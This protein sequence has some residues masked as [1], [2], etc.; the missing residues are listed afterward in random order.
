VD[1][2]EPI[3]QLS[4]QAT[5]F[6]MALTMSPP[7]DATLAQP[8]LY[9]P[10]VHTMGAN[11]GPNQLSQLNDGGH[12]SINYGPCG[13]IEDDFHV[14]STQPYVLTHS[15]SGNLDLSGFSSA[16]SG[17]AF[18]RNV[19]ARFTQ[20][21]ASGTVL[22]GL[23]STGQALCTGALTITYTQSHPVVSL[24]VTYQS[25]LVFDGLTV[26]GALTGS[27]TRTIVATSAAAVPATTSKAALFYAALLAFLGLLLVGRVRATQPARVVRRHR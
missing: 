16:A 1:Y 7:P 22:L 2:E 10:A 19:T 14:S 23:A 17:A 3:P 21:G 4:T 27:R 8:W 12:I 13:D 11:E 6:R 24:P 26:D 15:V 9:G 18:F 5:D 20:S 25:Q